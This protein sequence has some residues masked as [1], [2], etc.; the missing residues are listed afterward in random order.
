MSEFLLAAALAFWLG[1]LTSISPCPLASNIAAV[2][3]I[4][5]DLSSNWK[6]LLSGTGYAF[7][8]TLTYVGLSVVLIGGLLAVPE[9]SNWL[10]KYMNLLLGPVLILVGMFLLELLSISLPSVER[11]VNFAQK[12][13]RYGILGA[14]ALGAVFALSF[15]PVSAALFFGSLIPLAVNHQ[16]VLVLP[17]LYGIGTALPVIAFGVII[18]L[19]VK[20]LGVAFKRVTQVEVWFRRITGVVFILVGVWYSATYIFGL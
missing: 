16:S 14:V 7:G 1:I 20:N 10:Q 8:R 19:G 5:K 11:G 9:V 13:K 4:G 15:C 17:V 18:A 12:T 3:F 2:S 6:A